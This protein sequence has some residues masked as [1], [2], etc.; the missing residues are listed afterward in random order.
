[1]YE[2]VFFPLSDMGLI[3]IHSIPPFHT[4]KSGPTGCGS[5]IHLLSDSTSG[6]GV[7]FFFF[8]FGQLT[9]PMVLSNPVEEGYESKIC[10]S[11]VYQSQHSEQRKAVKD[12]NATRVSEMGDGKLHSEFCILC[13]RLCTL[14]RQSSEK[15][16][17]SGE[18]NLFSWLF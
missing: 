18:V 16:E 14:R 9:E 6:F 17:Q 7:G 10:R 5:H 15:L 8:F 4:L 3:C 13:K 1:M 2:G 11:V 12:R